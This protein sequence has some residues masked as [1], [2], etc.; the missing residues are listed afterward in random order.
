MQNRA[1]DLIPELREWNAGKGIDLAGFIRAIG[2]YDHAIAYAHLF[3]PNFVAYD[4]CVFREQPAVDNYL[5]WLQ[6]FGGDR[7]KVE[8]MLNH[9]HIADMFPSDTYEPTA[10]I[11]KYL[12]LLLKDMWESKLLR[13]FPERRFTVEVSEGSDSDLL[14]Y[15]VTLFQE[16]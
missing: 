6:N 12:A 1:S 8:G 7:S 4:D 14:G 9:L 16:R 10:A 15:E 13:D 3:W 2:R 11:L 5:I